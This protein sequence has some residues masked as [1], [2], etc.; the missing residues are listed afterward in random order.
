MS[1]LYVCREYETPDSEGFVVVSSI[2]EHDAR[3]RSEAIDDF[4]KAIE[5]ESVI[6]GIN[7]D[8]VKMQD[9]Y[10]KAKQLKEQINDR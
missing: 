4:V 10:I 6:F 9:I 7:Y 1:K 5:K 8:Y 3:I 2:E